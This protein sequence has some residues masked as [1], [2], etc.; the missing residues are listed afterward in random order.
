MGEQ[1]ARVVGNE[2]GEMLDC[3]RVAFN[4]YDDIAAEVPT[5]TDDELVATVCYVSAVADR[6]F[7]LRG[8]CM[9]E[10][11]RRIAER[12]EQA[13]LE[14]RNVVVQIE[15]GDLVKDIVKETGVTSRSLRRDEQIV[16][17]LA[18]VIA[19]R[20]RM[21]GTDKLSA[22]VMLPEGIG[23]EVAQVIARDRDPEE[24]YGVALDILAD[25]KTVVPIQ[26]FCQDLHDRRKE[27]AAESEALAVEAEATSVL[28]TVTPIRPRTEYI[29]GSIS[30]EAKAMLLKLMQ[31]EG[32]PTLP[33]AIERAIEIAWDVVSRRRS[34]ARNAVK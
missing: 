7:W 18:P 9:V 17:V 20:L 23:I 22:L 32:L 1:L 29:S 33:M 24:A 19:E 16:R 3:S 15:K 14:G 25:G 27:A 13:R 30:F 11:D 8:L 5:M 28:A 12:A 10:I 31:K 21:T 34:D 6:A 26:Q 2:L 4:S